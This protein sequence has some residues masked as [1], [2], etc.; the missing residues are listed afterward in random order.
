M[1]EMEITDNLFAA[2]DIIVNKKLAEIDFDRT[3][4]VTIVKKLDEADAY[5]V[6]YKGAQFK[7]YRINS[8]DYLKQ[9]I[10]YMLIPRNRLDEDKFLL[11]PVEYYREKGGV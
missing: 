11:G 1:T 7:A 10:A 9:D 2:I 3:V 6:D 8:F 5:L 4:L